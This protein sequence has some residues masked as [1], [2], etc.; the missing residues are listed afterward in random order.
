MSSRGAKRKKDEKVTSKL[1][2]AGVVLVS[3][4]APFFIMYVLG[5]FMG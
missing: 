3:V 1:H 2:G 4:C 5:R